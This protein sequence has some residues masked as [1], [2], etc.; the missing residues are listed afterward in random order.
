MI[1]IEVHT[2]DLIPAV[3]Q[4]PLAEEVTYEAIDTEDEHLLFRCHLGTAAGAGTEL[5]ALNEIKVAGHLSAAHIDTTI[6]LAVVDTQDILAAGNH[7]RVKG[8]N[9]SRHNLAA[10]ALFYLRG[11]PEE[12]LV[13]TDVAECPGVRASDSADKIPYVVRRLL[14]GYLTVCMAASAEIGRLRM[15]LRMAGGIAALYLRQYLIEQSGRCLSGLFEEALCCVILGDGEFLLTDDV[16]VIGIRGH[17]MERDTGLLLAVDEHPVNRAAA[18]I[19]RQERAMQ[20]Q[21]THGRNI[22][23]DGLD[24]GAI[25]E[26]ENDI[27]SE[28]LYPLRPDRVVDVVRGEDGDIF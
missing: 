7:Q 22:E 3:M 4:E 14:P 9:G 12:V 15:V 17:V 11:R 2:I 27:G 1:G 26:R 16:A 23:N 28:F 8:E 13:L 24:H 20:I 5:D 18:P 21:T 19:L 25:V 10:S 6:S